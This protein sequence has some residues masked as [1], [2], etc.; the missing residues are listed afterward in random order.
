M[1]HTDPIERIISDALTSAGVRFVGEHDL[2]QQ[3]AK[4]LDFYLPEQGIQ[5][6]C[7]QFHS[8]RAIRQL[9]K[10]PDV[11]L[12]QGRKAALAFAEMIAHPAR[13]ERPGE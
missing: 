6:E 1:S 12:I 8:E 2:G 13:P 11:I 10:H 3:H 4:N 7:K 9:A 5:I